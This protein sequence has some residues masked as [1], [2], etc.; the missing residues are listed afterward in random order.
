MKDADECDDCASEE[1]QSLRALYQGKGHECLRRIP[2]MGTFDLRSSLLI[3]SEHMSRQA[4][5]RERVGGV[6]R[7]RSLLQTDDQQQVEAKERAIKEAKQVI[8]DLQVSPGT[9]QACDEAMH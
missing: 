5:A 3:S 7:G 6:R 4:H 2:C 9:R 8:A 1:L